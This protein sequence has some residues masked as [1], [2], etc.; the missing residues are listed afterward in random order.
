MSEKKYVMPPAGENAKEKFGSFIQSLRDHLTEE[1]RKQ[2]LIRKVLCCLLVLLF[3]NSI[4]GETMG[5]LGVILAI[6]LT[7]LSFLFWHY[8]Y[9]NF[10][11][12]VLQTFLNGLIH[13]ESFWQIVLKTILQYV[14]VYF[15][16]TLIAPISGYLTWR[17]AVKNDK[18]LYIINERQ[19]KWD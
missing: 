6:L 19:D 5:I 15:W 10:Q 13:F 12:G 7:S 9:W 14:L 3:W 8:A 16:I 4:L 2:F 1:Y 18:I 17:K 11:G